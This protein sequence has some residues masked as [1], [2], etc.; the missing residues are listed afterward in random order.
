MLVISYWSGRTSEHIKSR[1][2]ALQCP[3]T[4][5][6]K[7]FGTSQ[8]AEFFSP[9]PPWDCTTNFSEVIFY[10]V[11]LIFS[12]IIMERVGAH[13]GARLPKRPLRGVDPRAAYRVAGLVQSEA[14]QSGF[15][16]PGRGALLGLRVAPFQ[17][18]TAL[19]LLRG[20]LLS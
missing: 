8:T 2:D 19:V 1:I 14:P 7:L 6:G 12:D 11:H 13:G 10:V 16:V 4:R 3:L 15:Q 5:T 17:P 18:L 9:D 20:K